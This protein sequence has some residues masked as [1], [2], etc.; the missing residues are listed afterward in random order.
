MN[1]RVIRLEE[2]VAFLEDAI[3]RL[4]STVEELNLQMLALRQEV[5]NIRR[6]TSPIDATEPQGA[7]QPVRR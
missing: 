7:E 6:Q 3:S 4:A 1:D 2:K 5:H